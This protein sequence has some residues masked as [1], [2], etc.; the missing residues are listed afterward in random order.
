MSLRT[1]L[2]PANA[3][4]GGFGFIGN[5]ADGRVVKY[6]NTNFAAHLDRAQVTGEDLGN[7]TFGKYVIHQVMCFPGRFATLGKELT[8]V[9]GACMA[10]QW[11][12]GDWMLAFQAVIRLMAIFLFFKM[13]G[14]DSMLAL[15]PTNSI[16]WTEDEKVDTCTARAESIRAATEWAVPMTNFIKAFNF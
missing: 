16:F 6:Q 8:Q 2:K 12:I 13:V 1:I 10:W 4:I 7:T 3:I 5:M 14:R 15:I 11:S 9:P